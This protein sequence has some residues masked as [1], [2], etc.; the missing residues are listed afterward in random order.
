MRIVEDSVVINRAAEEIWPFH[1]RFFQHAMRARQQ[2]AWSASN[3]AR[4]T[5]DLGS[6][7]HGRMAILGFETR[8]SYVISG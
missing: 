7:M 5:R 1:D 4:P 2:H 3:L 6:T 8:L